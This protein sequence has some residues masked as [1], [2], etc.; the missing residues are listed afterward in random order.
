MKIVSDFKDYY[1]C[2]QRTGID[3][4]VVYVRRTS[5]FRE[6]QQPE[7]WQW[8][9]DSRGL[10]Y[11]T[12]TVGFCGTIYRAVMFYDASRPA[13]GKPLDHAVPAKPLT[14]WMWS[15]PKI[16][17]YFDE[18][19]RPLERAF[20]RQEFEKKMQR[21]L[22]V[23]CPWLY[24]DW[25]SKN[26]KDEDLFERAPIILSHRTRDNRDQIILNPR[27]NGLSF[28]KVL[29]PAQAYQTLCQWMCN[30]ARP[31][32]YIPPVSN[33]DLIEA[34]GFDLKYSFRKDKASR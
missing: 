24:H 33:S 22:P 4:D 30:Q 20:Y 32:E 18:H 1:D 17:D 15:V 26:A 5:V 31:R 6:I 23:T 14:G 16:R 12:V 25:S 27:L 2:M 3:L 19:G 13:G 9:H 29:D 10:Y 34:K 8:L 7:S 28:Q 21:L 11:N